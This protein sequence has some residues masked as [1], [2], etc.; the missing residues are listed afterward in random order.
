MRAELRRI[1]LLRT[2]VNRNNSALTIA[3]LFTDVFFLLALVYKG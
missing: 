1:I 2:R 3:Y